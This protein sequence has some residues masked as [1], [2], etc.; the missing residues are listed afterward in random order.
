MAEAQQAFM[1]KGP[2]GLTPELKMAMQQIQVK[3]IEIMQSKGYDTSM[4]PMPKP[5]PPQ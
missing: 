2:A 4:I 3:M 5:A 1:T